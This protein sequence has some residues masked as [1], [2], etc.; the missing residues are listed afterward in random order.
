MKA[1]ALLF[2]SSL[3]TTSTSPR[4]LAQTQRWQTELLLTW[5]A[6]ADRVQGPKTWPDITAY[7][8]A[9]QAFYKARKRG[10]VKNKKLTLIDFSKPSMVPRLWV[11][12][13]TRH[14][15]I[16]QALVAHGQGTGAGSMARR[17]SNIPGSHQS[18]LGTYIVGKSYFGNFG[19]A[20]YVR[21]LE[22][23]L[24]D[25]A[26]P[27][28]IRVHALFNM[29]NKAY[30]PR[31]PWSEVITTYG[32]FGIS[33]GT[34]QAIEN[35]QVVATKVGIDYATAIINMIKGGSV[36]VAYHPQILGKS[37]Y[38]QISKEHSVLSKM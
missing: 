17:F 32:C 26:G 19:Y 2:L 18:S 37:S 22:R 38:V 27:R 30:N 16:A 6:K 3:M 9:R 5:Q 15:I 23:G 34:M 4:L 33:D 7:Q 29:M 28:T 13:M 11:I 12:D 35:G 1:V 20:A 25:K 8:A 24:N 21:G 36:L 10:L 14:A 31:Y